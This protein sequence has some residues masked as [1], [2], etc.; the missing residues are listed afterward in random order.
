MQF[1]S[2]NSSKARGVMAEDLNDQPAEF[3][4]FYFF[5]SNF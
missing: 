1:L 5:T 4:F 2:G 3:A